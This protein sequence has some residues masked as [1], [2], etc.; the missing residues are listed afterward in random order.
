MWSPEYTTSTINGL[1]TCSTNDW[2]V[3]GATYDGVSACSNVKS[4]KISVNPFRCVQYNAA[5]SSRDIYDCGACFYGWKFASNGD[6]VSYESASR[7]AGIR[8]K[9]FFVPQIIKSLGDMRSCLMTN[10]AKLALLC[11]F[12]E[13]D[14]LA[15]GAKATCVQKNRVRYPFAKP[16]TDAAPCA[17]YAVKNNQVV[18]TK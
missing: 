3:S 12:I 6:V 9:A 17:A 11:D 8:L 13:R 1:P 15:P 10:D 18:C 2:V 4:T 14:S 5:K 16:L 7:A